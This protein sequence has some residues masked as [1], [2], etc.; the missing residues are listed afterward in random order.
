MPAARRES[1]IY[2]LR[3]ELLVQQPLVQLRAVGHRPAIHRFLHGGAR[4]P[5]MSRAAA[6]AA[7]VLPFCRNFVALPGHHH[8][9][10]LYK[11]F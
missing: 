11:V 6:A 1:A 8:G 9:T 10:L 3:V 5:A 2:L 4:A 7:T